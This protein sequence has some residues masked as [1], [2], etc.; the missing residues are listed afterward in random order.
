M[1]ISGGI[2]EQK[3]ESIKRKIQ[4]WNPDLDL[5]TIDFQSLDT[6]SLDTF[7]AS[8]LD[9]YMIDLNLIEKK[10]NLSDIK[11]IAI[12]KQEQEVIEEWLKQ[13]TKPLTNDIYFYA[14][15]FIEMVIHKKTY[16]CILI[17]PTALGK[18]SLAISMCEQ[19]NKEYVYITTKAT[20][21]GLYKD[22]FENNKDDTIIILDEIETLLNN[23]DGRKILMSALWGVKDDL[24]IMSYTTSKEKVPKKFIFKPRIIMLLNSINKSKSD[25]LLSRVL[26]CEINPNWKERIELIKELSNKPYNKISSEI[27]SEIALF[28]EQNTNEATES[29]NL[30]TLIKGYQFYEFDK[31]N[32]KKLLLN[33][34]KADKTK[35]YLIE[36]LQSG[37][38]VREQIGEFTKVTGL[39][40]RTYFNLKRSITNR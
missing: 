34:L 18:T 32:W 22:L 15:K 27:R 13:R 19:Y 36:I 5:E 26:T 39:S 6:T 9:N 2:T 12:E 37:M 33:E 23:E 7:K 1:G 11:E 16:G 40:S 25:A 24:R 3:L 35:S 10:T 20:P 30:R 14:K 29:L 31:E 21:L 17:S 38:T 4:K 8:L 28:I